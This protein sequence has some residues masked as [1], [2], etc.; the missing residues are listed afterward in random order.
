MTLQPE[1][2]VVMLGHVDHG[3]T[4]ITKAL[5][6][7]WTD[8]HS[9]EVKRGITIKIGYADVEIYKC[10]KCAGAAAFGTKKA[11]VHCGSPAEMVRKFSIIDAPGH[12]TL[13]TTAIAASS[14]TDGAILVIAAN[15]ECPQPQTLEHLMVLEILGID[16]I[17]VVQNKVD[18]VSPEKARENYAKIKEFL[19]GT[20]AENAPIIPM[21]ANYGINTDALLKA[22]YEH[23]PVPERNDKLP[24]RMYVARS[25]DVNKPG[26]EITRL[27]GAVVGGSIIQGRAKVGDQIEISPGIA[28]DPKKGTY[29]KIYTTIT[30]IRSGGSRVNE[31]GPGGL[32]ALSTML[33]PALAKSDGLVGQLVGKPGTLPEPVAEVNIEYRLLDRAD[34]QMPAL[35][36]SEPIVI[37]VGTAVSVGIVKALKKGIASV[38]LK[39]PIVVEK[40]SKVAIS[41]RVGNRW[42]LGGFGIVK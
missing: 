28:I 42:R 17:V 3:K 23:V 6:G 21:A 37:S 33:D 24:L 34:L 7:V 30:E 15:E 12:E 39:R 10:P 32:L 35:Q 25:F 1:I 16:K 2:N 11:C 8:T 41:R 40:G 22:I 20:R 26:S 27:V 36:Q 19:K 29:E 5:S 9:E 18:V 31:A 38:T 13:M 14:I 4:S